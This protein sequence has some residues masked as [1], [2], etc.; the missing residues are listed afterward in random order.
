M[1]G[2]SVKTLDL[3]IYEKHPGTEGAAGPVYRVGGSFTPY[4]I[5]ATDKHFTTAELFAQ[6]WFAR[7]M[8]HH[9]TQQDKLYRFACLP[10]EDTR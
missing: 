7:A 4:A 10:H 5:V 2:R 1:E 3:T 8:G 9:P 6:Y